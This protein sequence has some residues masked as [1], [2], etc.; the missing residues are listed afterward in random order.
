M[1]VHLLGE[2]L[3]KADVRKPVELPRDPDV[4]RRD[5]D[6]LH[7]YVGMAG[8]QRHR[9]APLAA[10]GVEHAPRAHAG[11]LAL[12]LAELG[13]APAP[14]DH[15]ARLPAEE[16]ADPPLEELQ[17]DLPAEPLVLRLLGRDVRLAALE[18]REPRPDPRRLLGVAEVGMDG[19]RALGQLESGVD[20]LPIELEADRLDDGVDVVRV[21]GRLCYHSAQFS[22]HLARTAGSAASRNH[23]GRST[24]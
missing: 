23:S 22:E 4:R 1:V 6:A 20:V 2:A 9:D 13:V 11:D 7:A 15:F 16:D 5:L 17:P 24:R 19:V 8:A 14:L 21:H 3:A 12:E 10:P 18:V